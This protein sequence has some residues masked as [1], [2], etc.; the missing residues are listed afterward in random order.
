MA[1]TANELMDAIVELEA[2]DKARAYDIL[3]TKCV[4]ATETMVR[5]RER[6]CRVDVDESELSSLERV[7]EELRDLGYKFRFIERQNKDGEF[8][9]FQILISIR[10]CE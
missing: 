1:K 8:L 3:R 4:A 7:T 9:T 10:H 5:E 2:K 6:E